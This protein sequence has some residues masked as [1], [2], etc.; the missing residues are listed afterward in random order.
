MTVPEALQV[1]TDGGIKP[2]M[3]FLTLLCECKPGML[4]YFN[5]PRARLRVFVFSLFSS[6]AHS[7]LFLCS[8]F[9]WGWCLLFLLV[10]CLAAPFYRLRTRGARASVFFSCCFLLN[11]SLGKGIP[12]TSIFPNSSR[13]ADFMR[14]GIFRSM[15]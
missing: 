5:F 3:A 6:A 14:S 2:D 7:S 1:D 13:Y 10:L 12:F 4:P 11:Y 15:E 9:S 8:V